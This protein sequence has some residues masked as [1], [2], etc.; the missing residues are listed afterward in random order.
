MAEIGDLGIHLENLRLGIAQRE[1]E[2]NQNL[3]AFGQYP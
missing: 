1:F 2:A 3:L